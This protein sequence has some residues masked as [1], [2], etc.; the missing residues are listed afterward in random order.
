M[1]TGTDEEAVMASGRK[2]RKST[3]KVK[4]VEVKK[5]SQTV[6]QHDDAN[7]KRSKDYIPV[8]LS[9]ES[10]GDLALWSAG[11]L[12][13]GCD[14]LQFRSSTRK[15]IVSSVGTQ[16]R[17]IDTRANGDQIAKRLLISMQ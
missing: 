9:M 2:D 8:A 16:N 17:L 10:M 1:T 4:V 14:W 7:K 6:L 13:K 15:F 12:D 11:Y 5:K 3:R